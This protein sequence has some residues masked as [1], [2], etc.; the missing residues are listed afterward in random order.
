MPTLELCVCVVC[1]CVFCVYVC[2]CVLA[3]VTWARLYELV[4]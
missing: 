3:S 1:V 2:M 4:K